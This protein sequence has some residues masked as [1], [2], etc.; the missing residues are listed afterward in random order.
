MDLDCNICFLDTIHCIVVLLGI[1]TGTKKLN[2]CTSYE[3]H[4]LSH[5]VNRE[6]Q[7]SWGDLRCVSCHLVSFVNR[8]QVNSNIT[9]SYQCIS[10]ENLECLLSSWYPTPVLSRAHSA[11]QTDVKARACLRGSTE[12]CIA[13][14]FPFP[15]PQ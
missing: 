13:I 15:L 9:D 10:Y 6:Y 2:G 11:V 8:R 12:S 4:N 1:T 14:S 3:S 7:T 5:V